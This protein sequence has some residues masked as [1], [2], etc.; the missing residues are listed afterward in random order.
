MATE[1]HTEG[2]R[3]AR[4]KLDKAP[5]TPDKFRK[6]VAKHTLWMGVAWATGFTFVAYFIPA[7]ELVIDHWTGQKRIA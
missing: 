3:N 7:R 1:R 5:M 2:E 4:I 6:K